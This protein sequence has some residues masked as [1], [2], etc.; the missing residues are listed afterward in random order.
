MR[1]RHSASESLVFPADSNLGSS[2]E[3]FDL[4]TNPTTA[5]GHDALLTLARLM[6]R[7]AAEAAW[8]TALNHNPEQGEKP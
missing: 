7:Q 3:R 6:G 4:R 8:A 1:C 5:T 2:E